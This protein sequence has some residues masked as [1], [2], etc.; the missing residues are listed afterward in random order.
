MLKKLLNMIECKTFLFI[1]LA[2]LSFEC[3]MLDTKVE[4]FKSLQTIEKENTFK[5]EQREGVDF[6]EPFFFDYIPSSTVEGLV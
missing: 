2:A 6:Y 4:D 1:T 3:Y 5:A